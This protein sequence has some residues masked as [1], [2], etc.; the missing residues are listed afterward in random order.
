MNVNDK[1]FEE[2]VRQ[3]IN[4]SRVEG[5]FR[6]KVIKDLTDLE[7]QIT[8]RLKDESDELTE[9]KRSRLQSLL[10]DIGSFIDDTYKSIDAD[11]ETDL[12]SLIEIESARTAEM[13]SAVI[14]VS[15][16]KLE[17]PTINS[18]YSGLIVEGDVIGNW[19]SRQSTKTKNLY[20]DRIRQGVLLGET[21]QQIIRKITG[22][23]VLKYTD[24]IASIAKKDAET[25]VRTSVQNVANAARFKTLEANKSVFSK[26]THV[27]TLD[28]RTS[29]QCAARDGLS[30]DSETKE[31]I[32]HNLPFLVPPVHW[33][34]RSTLVPVIEGVK[35]P[36]D[37]TRASKEGPVD[38]NL[39]FEDYLKKKGPDFQD[40]VL[41]KKRAE[42]WRSNKLN[43]RQLLDTRGNPLSVEQL[44]N[45]YKG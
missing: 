21:N 20:S 29:V 41:G 3:Q 8:K 7:K 1:I 25:L 11:V 15:F 27:A 43:L 18:L 5:S 35:L 33:N 32:G 45:L 36:A 2:L 22:T 30:W 19:W 6:N 23:K 13:A 40:E 12:K 17:A 34:C 4:A 42:L 24:G 26:Y 38:I 9:A 39:K 10:N 14:D 16:T 31:P 28:S 44:K 37:A